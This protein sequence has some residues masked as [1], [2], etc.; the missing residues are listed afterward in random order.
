MD[1]VT[2]ICLKDFH[3]TTTPSSVKTYPLVDFKSLVLGIQ[4]VS[5][6]SFNIIG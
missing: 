1:F 3:D 2:H 6:Y 4:F 5:L